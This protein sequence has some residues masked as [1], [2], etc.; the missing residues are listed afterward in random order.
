[1]SG[2]FIKVPLMSRLVM[3]RVVSNGYSIACGGRPGMTLAQQA[4]TVGWT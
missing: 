4:E 1:M 2:F 3:V